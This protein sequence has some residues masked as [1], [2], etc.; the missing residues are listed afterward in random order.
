M[1]R[2]VII[3]ALFGLAHS[4]PACNTFTDCASCT[5]HRT[6]MPGQSCRWCPTEHGANCHAE[7]SAYD[8]CSSKNVIT[9]S[10][11]CGAPAP[12]PAPPIPKSNEANEIMEALF[13][14]L[15]INANATACVDDVGGAEVKFHD[16]ASHLKSGNFSMAAGDLSRALDAL[17]SSVAECHVT[18]MQAKI[19]TIAA[20]IRWA[21]VTLLD[22]AVHMI[23]GASDLW[24]D[25]E[26]VGAAVDNKD[27]TAVGNAIGQL[28]QAWTTVTG[29][30]AANSTTCQFIDGLLKMVQVIA[31][32]VAPCEVALSPALANLTRGFQLFKQKQFPLAI[33]EM[34]AGLDDIAVAISADSCGLS[35]VGQALSQVAPKLAAA[36]VQAEGSSVKIIVG[37]ADVY[38]DLYRAAI[39]LE[40]GDMQGFGVDMGML[41]STLRSSACNSTAC[42]L[43]EGVLQALQLEAADWTACSHDVDA[44]GSDF[45]LAVQQLEAKNW[46]AGVADLG[47]SITALS[48]GVTGCG[49]TQLAKVLEDTA[50]KL[51][52]PT[53]AAE[54]GS[55]VQILVDGSDLTLDLAQLVADAKAGSWSSVGHDL[56]SLSAWLQQTGCESFVCKLVEGILEASAIP[57]RDLKACEGDLKAAEADF[58]AGAASMGQK[59]YAAAASYW[60]S[61]LN[62]VAKST[63]DCGLAAELQYVQ[64]EANL[65]GFGNITILGEVA[66]VVIHGSDFYEELFSTFQAFEKHDYRTAG[67]ELGKVLNSLSNWTTGHACTAD[68]CYVVMG[69]M[70]YLGDLEG[71]IKNCEHDIQRSWGNLTAAFAEFRGHS[72]AL[73]EVSAAQR[74]QSSADFEFNRNKTQIKNGIRDIGYAFQDIAAGVGHCHLQDLE[75]ILEQLAVKLGVAPEVQWL[76][77]LLKILIEGVQIENEIGGACVDFSDD[78]WIGFGYNIAK[79]IRTLI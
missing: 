78:N 42:I 29:G 16:F 54:I 76:E 53:V 34:A 30:C 65:L 14:M 27:P 44:A 3:V 60:A 37:A 49:L 70:Q 10:S 57:L 51:G 66:S 38:D 6:W 52:A 71:D 62:W 46:S 22:D 26:A 28:L 41:L 23:V 45:A 74:Y 2:C 59:Q 77:T 11:K 4:S 69:V 33:A 35:R 72:S 64:Q 1:L 25:I 63:G 48:T 18:D 17:S 36:I 8:S 7:W 31:S 56:G 75:K 55:V 9:S 68:A 67:A 15:G 73:Q 24:K 79:L 32:D 50:S 13:T 61:G 20:A 21:N 5:T 39:A 43:L 40:A 47:K 12:T 19:D 58:S